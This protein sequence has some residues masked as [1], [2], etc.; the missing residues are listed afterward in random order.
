MFYRTITI[1]SLE[2]LN[3]VCIARYFPPSD[4]AESFCTA[5]FL[6]SLV[7]LEKYQIH[8]ITFAS[9]QRLPK[10]VCTELLD[11]RIKV[12]YLPETD[13]PQEVR[14]QDFI[15]GRTPGRQTWPTGMTFKSIPAIIDILKS[16]DSPPILISRDW[17]EHASWLA[18]QVKDYALLWVAHFADPCPP[19]QSSTGKSIFSRIKDKLVHRIVHRRVQKIFSKADMLTVTCRNVARFFAEEYKQVDTQ[20]FHLAY[21]VGSPR[22]QPGNLKLKKNPA[23]F[24]I[25]HIG[26]LTPARYP[27]RLIEEFSAAAKQWTELRLILFGYIDGIPESEMSKHSWLKTVPQKM[28]NP[29][30]ATDLLHQSDMN[31]VVDA[32]TLLS[33]CP[34]LASKTVYAIDS[35]KPLLGIGVEDSEMAKLASE[36]D[37]TYFADIKK[38]GNL[39]QVLLKIKNEQQFLK[40]PSNRLVDLFS[41]RAVAE[42]FSNTLQ[43]QLKR[44]E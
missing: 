5:R 14:W 32:E 34:F 27:Q 15:L 17:T 6:A 39:T 38:P 2:M 30:D 41:P 25:I 9:P 26:A 18:Y 12:T 37:S 35:K 44:K 42:S 21:H 4:C 3:I 36:F 10:D 24:S 19:P 8:V 22:L 23:E 13:A 7:A 43:R 11:P 28:M 20:K 31:M 40:C 33:Y 1:E 16:Y 29:R